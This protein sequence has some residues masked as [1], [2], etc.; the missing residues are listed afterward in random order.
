MSHLD[1]GQEYCV[2]I[3]R[4]G[5]NGGWPVAR[6][7]GPRADDVDRRIEVLHGDVDTVVRVRIESVTPDR[8]LG[9]IVTTFDEDSEAWKDAQQTLRTQYDFGTDVVEQRER[10]RLSILAKRDYQIQWMEHRREI[11]GELP[12]RS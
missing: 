5:R 9:R 11:F 10:Y 8:G 7:I 2:V 6:P 12:N 4:D 3:W 1:V